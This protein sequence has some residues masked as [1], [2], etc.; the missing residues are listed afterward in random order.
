MDVLGVLL[1]PLYDI[2]WTIKKSADELGPDLVE[3]GGLFEGAL[4]PIDPQVVVGVKRA[5][6]CRIDASLVDPIPAGN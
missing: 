6:L 2:L 5:L 1:K 4:V 3:D